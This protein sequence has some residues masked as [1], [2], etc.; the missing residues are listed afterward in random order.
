MTFARVRRRATRIAAVLVPEPST[1]T[2]RGANRRF[3]Q[4]TI[5]QSSSDCRPT[6]KPVH[7]AVCVTQQCNRNRQEIG[8]IGIS[9]RLHFEADFTGWLRENID[10][11]PVAREQI[12]EILK[13]R[14]R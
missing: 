4:S 1:Q 5:E 3:G 14:Q 6:T 7:Q 12:E 8:R 11:L 9:S 10:K 13:R 2:G